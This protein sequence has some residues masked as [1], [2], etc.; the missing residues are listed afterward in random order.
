M[1]PK[2]GSVKAPKLLVLPERPFRG[3]I[4]APRTVDRADVLTTLGDISPLPPALPPLLEIP[5]KMFMSG[6]PSLPV[7]FSSTDQSTIS[8]V[9]GS[10]IIGYAMPKEFPDYGI[11]LSAK[12][13]STFCT[14]VDRWRGIIVAGAV[15]NLQSEQ[16][17]WERFAD[18][19]RDAVERADELKDDGKQFRF[20]VS[21]DG[22]MSTI[23]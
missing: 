15:K 7:S 8:S 4:A 20:V 23:E 11:H 12:G 16:G 6:G 9:A 5:E 10:L 22:L 21:K 13:S 19:V 2:S 1:E 3:Q 18:A 14:L 17:M